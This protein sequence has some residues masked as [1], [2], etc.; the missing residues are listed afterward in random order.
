MTKKLLFEIITK[1]ESIGCR[2]RG[3][4]M[5]LGNKT[6]LTQLGFDKGNY[7]FN[8]PVDPSRNVYMFPGK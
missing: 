7:Y 5:D 8:N 2:V 6:L 1:V 4:A 3:F